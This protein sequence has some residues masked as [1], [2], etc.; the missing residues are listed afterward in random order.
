MLDNA[1]NK[2]ASAGG[3]TEIQKAKKKKNGKDEKTK[4]EP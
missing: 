4:M 2:A 1:N 3:F